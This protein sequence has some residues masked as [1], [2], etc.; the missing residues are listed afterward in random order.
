MMVAPPPKAGFAPEASALRGRGRRPISPRRLKRIR[1]EPLAFGAMDL[2]DRHD[3]EQYDGLQDAYEQDLVRAR[4]RDAAS[5]VGIAAERVTA[6]MEAT[7]L[8]RL[9]SHGA[10]V[11]DEDGASFSEE[12]VEAAIVHAYRLHTPRIVTARPPVAAHSGN[13]VRRCRPRSRG[14]RRAARRSAR[15]SPSREDDPDPDPRREPRRNS[16]LV[17]AVA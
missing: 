14:H 3:D 17:G 6:E 4:L 16:S 13:A 10:T 9:D 2:D 1:G 5:V 15:A 8:D 7:A 12:A 11:E